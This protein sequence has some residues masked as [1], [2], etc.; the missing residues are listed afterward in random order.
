METIAFFHI[1]AGHVCRGAVRVHVVA[2]ILRVVFN[3]KDQR[4][5]FVDRTVGNFLHQQANRVVVVGHV[6]LGSVHLVDCRAE[7]AGVVVHKANQSQIRQ[8]AV[9]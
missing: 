4:V 2:A 3:N 1:G 8:T 5:V 6:A 9:A 7:V